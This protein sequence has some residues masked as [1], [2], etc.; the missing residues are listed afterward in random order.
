MN[1]VAI[2][3]GKFMSVA[4]L[5]RSDDDVTFR[6]LETG[7]QA[8]HDLLVEWGPERLLVKV[9]N[10]T[11]WVY[12][13]A[14]GLGIAVQVAHSNTE[15][16]RWKR[17]KRKTDRDDALRLA[18]LSVSNQL[19]TV[20]MPVLRVRRWRALINYRHELVRR[21]TAIRNSI[22]SILDMQGYRMAMGAR[23]WTEEL[24]HGVVLSPR[25]YCLHYRL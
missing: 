12:A 18:R 15:R 14:V 24:G 7:P 25:A 22:R 2:D 11:G 8:V 23:A 10:V 17:V 20:C 1:L 19:P 5:C 6:S 16:W 4:C 9:G 3:L 13:I 21:R